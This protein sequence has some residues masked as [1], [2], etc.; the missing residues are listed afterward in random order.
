VGVIFNVDG[1][2]ITFIDQLVVLNQV[3]DSVRI[4]GKV[5]IV[6]A[7]LKGLANE[8]KKLGGIQLTFGSFGDILDIGEGQRITHEQENK[9]SPG[10]RVR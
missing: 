1:S 5:K 2:I 7:Q 9:V 8:V 10:I 6:N 4:V 3:S